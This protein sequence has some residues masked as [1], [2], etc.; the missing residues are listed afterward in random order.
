MK[1]HKGKR[2]SLLK[3]ELR[4]ILNT[5]PSFHSQID[6]FDQLSILIMITKLREHVEVK[7]KMKYTIK[8]IINN[9]HQFVPKRGLDYISFESQKKSPYLLLPHISGYQ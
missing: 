9:L 1:F 2:I 3:G 6:N 8:S 5:L 4:V 7:Q